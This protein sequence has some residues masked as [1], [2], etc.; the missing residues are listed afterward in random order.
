[1]RT[2]RVGPWE[3]NVRADGVVTRGGHR[4]AGR[5]GSCGVMAGFLVPRTQVSVS[6]LAFLPQTVS[7]NSGRM[8]VQKTA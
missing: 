8:I 6:D 2:P 5:A 1:M 7:A 4:G 3:M